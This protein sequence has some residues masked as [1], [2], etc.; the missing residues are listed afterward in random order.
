VIHSKIKEAVNII[1]EALL[2]IEELDKEDDG[3]Y[4]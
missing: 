2:L 1:Q 4:H 3:G